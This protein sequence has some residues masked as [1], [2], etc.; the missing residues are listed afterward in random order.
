MD[1]TVL[2]THGEAR[3]IERGRGPEIAGTRITV[4]DVLG[5]ERLGWPDE[6]TA[7]WLKVTVP[8]VE[9]A[10]LY[11]GEH[12][13]EVMAE[14]QQ[15]LDRAKRGNPPEIRAKLEAARARFLAKLDDRQRR[16]VEE[17]SGVGTN[18][19]AGTHGAAGGR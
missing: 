1:A 9:A 7:A 17:L 14:Y 5:Y 8:E 3:I 15:M 2:L 10:R 4:Y 18:G 13:G 6:R 11:I 19:A 16:R 12:R